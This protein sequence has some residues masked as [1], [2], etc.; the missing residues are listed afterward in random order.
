[1]ARTNT[2]RQLIFLDHRYGLTKL[3]ERRQNFLRTLMPTRIAQLCCSQAI[4]NPI[5][6]GG[7]LGLQVYPNLIAKTSLLR[8]K[9]FH[10]AP[11]R[12]CCLGGSHG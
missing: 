2:P 7:V 12:S 10:W 9:G 8:L 3:R 11:S 5:R 1:M 4:D 6:G